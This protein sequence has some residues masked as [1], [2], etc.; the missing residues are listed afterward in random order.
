MATALMVAGIFGPIAGGIVADLC[1]RSGRQ[2]RTM[3]VLSGLAL[4]SL[5]ASMFAVVTDATWASALI[6]A[7]MV[8][9]SATVAMSFTLFTVLIPN[10]LRGL[11]LSLLTAANIVV[12]G[13]LAPLVVSLL[14]GALGGPATIGK[15]LALTCAG[16]GI[17]SA[18]SFGFGSRHFRRTLVQRS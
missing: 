7:F 3:L 12:A 15:A 9:V 16:A 10:E 14:S 18:L 6:V 5:P 2:H 13:A 17:M 11:C 4:L 1:Q 8:V